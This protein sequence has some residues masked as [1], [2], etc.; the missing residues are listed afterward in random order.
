VLT[1]PLNRFPYRNDDFLQRLVHGWLPALPQTLPEI[2]VALKDGSFF[3]R[4]IKPIGWWGSFTDVGGYA[5]MNREIVWR[6]H[7]YGYLPRI[8]IHDTRKQVGKDA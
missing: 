1:D 2:A 6:L 5:N 4:E 7:N 3:D 8:D